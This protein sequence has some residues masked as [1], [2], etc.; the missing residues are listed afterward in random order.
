MLNALRMFWQTLLDA[1]A[2]RDEWLG[3]AAAILRRWRGAG[4]TVDHLRRRAGLDG[5]RLDAKATGRGASAGHRDRDGHRDGHRDDDS[6]ADGHAEAQA[7]AEDAAATTRAAPPPPAP[8]T[9][10][11]SGYTGGPVTD[12]SIFSDFCG[13]TPTA[14]TAA[15]T[16]T[17]TPASATATPTG[18]AT[19]TSS[20]L[21]HAGLAMPILRLVSLHFGLQ[22]QP[23]ADRAGARQRRHELQSARQSAESGRLAGEPSGTRTPI[24]ATAASA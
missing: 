4:A 12:D 19:G 15:P 14:T 8:P 10:A 17:D 1:V 23:V 9:P 22:L 2:A 11:A 3:V 13:A 6:H 16:A 21:G 18:S 20:A 24:A 7:C 5:A